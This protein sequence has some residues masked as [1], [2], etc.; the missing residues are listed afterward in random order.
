MNQLMSSQPMEDASTS[1]LPTHRLSAAHARARAESSEPHAAHHRR[2]NR[3]RR[4]GHP[5]AGDKDSCI[6]LAVDATARVPPAWSHKP[7]K[8][9]P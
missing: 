3:A 7:V 8:A 9:K 5:V 1:F 4:M 2:P 6:V